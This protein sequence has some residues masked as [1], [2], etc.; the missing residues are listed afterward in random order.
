VKYKQEIKK[1]TSL[2]SDNT[3]EILS[4]CNAIIAGGSITSVFCNREVNDIDV[5]F[6]SEQDY[7]VFLDLVFNGQFALVCNNYTD[8]SVLFKDKETGQDVQAIV[9]KFFPTV[10]DIFNDYDFTINM[11]ALELFTDVDKDNVVLHEDFL[12][13]NSQRYLQFNTGT[14]YPLIS[15]LRVNKYVEKGYTISK[16]QYLRIMFTISNLKLDD[17]DKVKDH[18]GGMY[19][20]DLNQVFPKEEEFS[21]E[22]VIEI[23]DGLTPDQKIW[24]PRQDID[25]TEI[26]DKYLGKFNDSRIPC[27]GYFK[28]VREDKDGVLS[29]FFTP[30]FKY[31]VGE[32]INGGDKGIYYEEGWEIV[33][34][35]YWDEPE[36][37]ILQLEGTPKIL[38][39][40]CEPDVL[41]GDVKV[42]E[43]LTKMQ[44]LRK[45]K[46]A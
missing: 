44:F 37:V 8:R 31:K 24:S 7:M 28:L 11:G 22:K 42:V 16:P 15:A 21:I 39:H 40:A 27:E 26:L 18:V 9:Y 2:L 6:R 4:A 41:M 34:G 20:L 30:S 23:L 19:G 32:V 3:L 10:G 45:Y 29:S 43:K 14:A 5:Y 1:L 46:K 25:Q 12:K 13:H 36:G 35:T 33:D 17:W 38:R